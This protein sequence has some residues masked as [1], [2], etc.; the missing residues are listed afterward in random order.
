MM[1]VSLHWLNQPCKDMHRHTWNTSF[2]D[3]SS[4][5][6]LSREN[7][8]ARPLNL[9]GMRWGGTEREKKVIL[10]TKF[11]SFKMKI[12]SFCILFDLQM[13]LQHDTKLTCLAL[14]KR[15]WQQSSNPQNVPARLLITKLCNIFIYLFIYLVLY[16][17]PFCLQPWQIIQSFG[18]F[19]CTWTL[20]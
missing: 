15:I 12:K 13:N 16:F 4:S 20:Y 5:M 1:T 11:Q 9:C 8:T 7:V 3:G 18:T 14:E 2:G 19:T 10:T 17:H 6:I